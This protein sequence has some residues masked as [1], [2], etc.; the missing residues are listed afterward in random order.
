MKLRKQPLF[1]SEAELPRLQAVLSPRRS[2]E[3]DRDHV[4]QLRK[5]LD[6]A[7]VLESAEMPLDVITIGTRVQ[8]RDVLSGARREMTLVLPEDADARF[9]RVSVL[10]PLGTALLGYREGDEVSWVMPGGPRRL[11]I[12]SVQ[13]PVETCS[14]AGA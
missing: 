3:R 10:A 11:N 2:D 8:V 12:E 4:E 7:V 14:R 13:R 6:R 9:H 5:E 1:I